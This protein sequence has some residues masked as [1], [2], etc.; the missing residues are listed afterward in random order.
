MLI[1][2]NRNQYQA[3][4]GQTIL[5]VAREN[6]IDIPTLCYDEHLS[7]VGACRM[8][9]VE[10][11]DNGTLIAA[12]STPAR[13]GMNILTESKKVYEA[14]KTVLDLLLSDHCG[15]CEA[16]C[17][18][19][20]PASLRVEE[21]VREAASGNYLEALKI[22][23]ERIPLP[24]SIGR[25]CPRFCEKDCRRNVI[26][27]EAV[28]INDFKRLAADLHYEEYLEERPELNGKKVAIVGAGPAGYSIAY[29]LRLEGI[30]SDIY[31]KMPEP[32]GM[33][34]YG[35]PEYRLP[36]DILDKELAHFEKMGGIKVRCNQE[37][38]KDISLEELKKDYDAV[39]IT[40]GSWKSSSMRVEGEELA[41]VGIKWLEEL[42]SN[43][44]RVKNPGKTLVV[45]GGNTAIDCLRSSVR[46]SDDEVHCLYRR[47]EKEMPAEQIEIDEARDEGVIFNFLTQP[48]KLR[49]ENGK[50]ILTC[51][52]MELGELDAS[53]RR[54]PIPVEGSEFELE[55]DTVIAAIGQKTETPDGVKAN[56]WGNVDV[57]P[58]NSNVEDNL[59]AAGDCVSGPA[60][61]VEALADGRKTALSI[62]SF[63]NGEKYETPY[64]SNVSRGHW[65][66]LD[67]EDLNLLEEPVEWKRN[68]QTL[69][70]LEERTSTFKEV[71]RTFTKEEIEKEGERCLECSCFAK[72]DCTLRDLATE[73][74]IDE[75]SFGTR[76]EPK[77]QLIVDNPFLILDS[78][79]CILCGKCVRV[80]HEV[81]S[82]YAY[83]FTERGFKT[84]I[85][86]PCD[87][88]LDGEFSNC[89]FCGQCVEM[90][91]TGALRY[92]PHAGKGREDEFKK[93]VTTCPYC[94]V[95]CQ[96]E[97]NVIDNKIV[98][99]GS[100]YRD[101]T[102]NP[103]GEACVKGRFGYSFVNHPDRLKTPMIKKDGEFVDVSWDEALEYTAQRLTEIKEKY[104]SDALAGLSS[105][106]CSNEENYLM[107]KFV[108]AVLG[109][110]SVDHC[111][112]LCHASTVAG[113]VK[114]FGSGA[115]TNSI[116]EVEGADV[117]FV[118][119]SNPTE[120]HP[121]IGSMMK[122]ALE[123]GTK[124][125]VADPRGIE[126]SGLADVSIN[127]RPGSDVALING[128]MHVIIEEE[129][130]DKEF[131]EER[132]ENFEMLKSVVSEYTPEMVSEI[133]GVPAEKIIEAACLYGSA[134]KGAIYFAMGI[135]Q[136]R[137]GTDNV[138]SVANLAMLTGNVGRE[139]TGVNPLRG[140]NNV[141][142]ACDLGALSNVYPGYQAVT[143][144]AMKEK[145][146]K[147]WGVEDLSDE[148]GLTVV[149]MFNK[150]GKGLKGLYIMGENPMI[151]DPDQN[152]IREALE[153][154]EFLVVQDIFLS[155]TAEYADVILPAASFAEK[156]GTFTN[157]ERRIQRINKA[158]EAP[159]QAR[160]D[161]EIICDLAR[162]M[163][164]EMSYNSV[165]EIMDEIA[166]VT[167][168]YGGI[169]YDRLGETGLQWPC[170]DREHPGTKF[171]HQGKFSRGKGKFNPASY[172]PPAEEPDE[173]YD[174]FM[175]TGRMLYQFHT[176]TMTRNSEAIN[177][178]QPDAYVEVNRE[179]AAEIGIEDGDRVRV[180]SRRGTVETYARVGER[181][182][183]GHLFMPFHYAESPAN[184]LTN[185]VLDPDAKI[186]E[187]KVSAVKMEKVH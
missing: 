10:M 104:G 65:Q 36:K 127:Q 185:S 135:T 4:P 59:F 89:V 69:I 53:G 183:K 148:I 153:E 78:D 79:K 134:E 122:R 94:G 146:A 55:A 136:H 92:V 26:D 76:T 120:N 20:C 138:L 145:F 18:L 57:D 51:I 52:K 103:A 140:Q 161:W 123:K 46:L 88:G 99:V 49:E 74:R 170:T 16:P 130:Y 30:A 167:P 163:G 31:E 28:A 41:E 139:S 87:Q 143:D 58:A 3:E 17:T 180:S 1:N 156:D 43:D 164:Y 168:I 177:I 110:N 132:T 60:T 45:G 165:A 109:T 101:G 154:I 124:L 29:Y 152:H 133:T 187:L 6:G 116:G 173:E 75:S 34:R 85:A 182:R 72:N 113:L 128:I 8:C 66:S 38:G 119:G 100:V 174:M 169:Y 15:D 5:D 27:E 80:D 62:K 181:V 56:K 97:L 114:A 121:V 71:A 63:L 37:L 40:V 24:M 47:T 115:M 158:V 149:E 70:S 160:P 159:G 32:G 84:K 13:D 35:I 157:T 137:T 106:K 77:F 42:S 151:S 176:G 105:A 108:R 96:L 144:P 90:C 131:V 111:A 150:I 21:Y 141:Q 68:P 171:L 61:V 19:N 83:D 25:V 175:M 102:P 82:S 73:F 129:L 11:E 81:Q 184:R 107:Q 155:E 147:A 54:R 117:I 172:I 162:R 64:K 91:P 126:L 166:E 142:G 67:K 22:I 9:M 39:A 118:T 23:K 98:R 7:I 93:V 86:T 95:G 186:P 33:L 2:I 12:C 44:W 48:I 50:K 179:D 125:I 178:Y 14:R 112:R